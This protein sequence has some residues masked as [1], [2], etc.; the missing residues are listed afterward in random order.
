MVVPPKQVQRGRH[1]S[2]LPLVIQP[3]CPFD[4]VLAMQC[5]ENEHSTFLDPLCLQEFRSC[6]IS[7][8]GTGIS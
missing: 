1:K 7:T 2:F 6:Q 3:E 5:A 8:R 4:I